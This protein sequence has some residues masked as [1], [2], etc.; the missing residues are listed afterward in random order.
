MK[1]FLQ[2]MKRDALAPPRRAWAMRHW[3]LSLLLLVMLQFVGSTAKAQ[4]PW[5]YDVHGQNFPGTL[6][7]Y[8]NFNFFCWDG[9][10]GAYDDEVWLQVNGKDVINLKTVWSLISGSRNNEDNLKKKNYNW[11]VGTPK[12][13]SKNGYRGTVALSN[14]RNT[15]GKWMG[16]TVDLILERWIYN[17]S[18]EITIRGKWRYKDNSTSNDLKVKV[19]TFNFPSMSWP[20]IDFKRTADGV[21]QAYST[22]LLQEKYNNCGGK[23][24]SGT[25]RYAYRFSKKY[26]GNVNWPSEP[27]KIE[28]YWDNLNSTPKKVK[29]DFV[30]CTESATSAY[31]T[32]KLDNFEA[33]CLHPF[34]TR[35][36]PNYRSYPLNGSQCIENN[37]YFNRS[38]ER[39]HW[40]NGY[41]RPKSIS[42]STNSWTKNVILSWTPE[43]AD[44]SHVTK[45]GKWVVFRRKSGS[46]TYE[47]LK[48]LAYSDKQVS[49]TDEDTKDY[50]TTYYYYVAFQPNEWNTSIMKPEDATNLY[51]STYTS[52]ST[53]N[54]LKS[55]LAS[56]NLDNKIT[57][58]CSFYSFENA[59]SSNPYKLLVYRRA[60]G[61]TDWGEVFHETTISDKNVTS[62]SFDDTKIAN[63]CVKYQYM[64][65][66]AAQ[67]TTFTSNICDGGI[68]GNSEVTSVNASRGAYSGTV[69]VNWDVKQVGTDLTYFNVRR[70]LLGS[71]AEYQNIYTTSGVA[72]TYTYEDNSAQPGSYYQ[73]EVECYRKCKETGTISP[74][75]S[76]ETDGFALATG[77]VSGRISYDTGTAVEGVKVIAEANNA[78]GE[79]LTAFHAL[80]T[81]KDVTCQVGIA[82]P[83]E[84]MASLFGNPWTAQTYIKID[85]FPEN[86]MHVFATNFFY[87]AVGSTGD[88]SIGLSYLKNNNLEI[89]RRYLD[90]KITIAKGKFYNASVSFDGNATYT[91][92]VIG[93]NGKFQSAKVQISDP[94]AYK[95]VD[96]IL[97]ANRDYLPESGLWY[98]DSRVDNQTYSGVIDECRFWTKEL[99]DDQIKKNYNHTL[100][101]SEDGLYLYYK[102][103]EGITN[104]TIAY[105]YSKTGGVSNGNHGKIVDMEITDDVPSENQ[106]SLSAI[107]DVNGN[108]TISG[109][110]FSGDGTSYTIRPSMGGHEFSAAKANRFVSAQ[111][112]VHNGVDFQDVSSFPVSGVVYYQGTTIPVEG[113]QFAVDGVSC[114][115]DGEFIQTNEKG[116]YTISVP[117]GYHYISAS[118]L[119]HEFCNAD[120]K[121]YKGMG[122]YP[123]QNE[124]ANKMET[125]EFTKLMPNIIFYDTT[126]VPIVGRVT[127]GAVEN[128]K[129]LGLGQSVNN[130]GQA[131]LTLKASD[132]Y[133]MNVSVE[134]NG[135]AYEYVT[136]K[137]DRVFAVPADAVCNSTT[138]VGSGSADNARI[139][140][141]KT[142]PKTGEFAAM[143]PPLQYTVTGIK[144]D[145]NSDISWN[146]AE[147]INATDP[148]ATSA[149][150]IEVEDGYKKFEYVASL[151]KSYRS[152]AILDVVQKNVE[153]EGAFGEP[154][155]ELVAEDGTKKSIELYNKEKTFTL[156]K[157]ANAD[158][159]TFGYPIFVQGGNY[160]FDLS[161]YE[162]YFNHDADA[163][164]KESK[165]PL[166][167][168]TVNITNQMGFGT[169]VYVTGDKDGEVYESSQTEIE[170]DSLGHGTYSWQAGSPNI[171]TPYTRTLTMS[172]PI[173]GV[174]KNWSGNGFQGIVL[175]QLTSGSNFVT[176]G[177]DEV[178]MILRDPAGSGSNAYVEEGQSF[179]TTK[180]RG[181]TIKY[182]NETSVKASMGCETTITT[183]TAGMGALVTK[184]TKIEVK[185]E[186][187]VGV[188]IDEEVRMGN[189]TVQT[190][191]TTKRISTSDQPEYVGDQGDVFIGS[192][193]N[194]NFGNAR[195]VGIYA[196]DA[197][198]VPALEKRDVMSVGTRYGTEFS[199][200]QNY[201]ENVLLPNF[202]KLRN[203]CLVHVN[204]YDGYVNNTD[205]PVYITKLSN[206][207]S[208]LGSNNSDKKVWGAKASKSGELSGESY[209]MVLP[210]SAYN[211]SQLK[212]DY[213]AS[214]TIAWYNAQISAWTQVLANNEK[215]KVTAIENAEYKRTNYSFDAGS[216]VSSSTQSVNSKDFTVESETSLL[217]V[218]SGK[219]GFAFDGNGVEVFTKEEKGG[220][221][222]TS[223]GS[224]E[225]SSRE[226]GFSLVET[227][228]AD[229]LSIDVIDAPDGF[230]PIFYTRAGQTSCPYEDEVKTKYY[231]PGTTIQTKTAQVEQP[232]LS[233]KETSVTGVPSGKP[234][235][236]TIYLQNTSEADIDSYFNLNVVDSSNPNG[237]A[238]KMDGKDVT[239]GRTILV[240]AGET[241]TKTL[242]ISQTNP[243]IYD[244]KDLQLRMSSTC[245]SNIE[246]ILKLSA[247]FQ[248]TSSDVSLKAAE[249]AV[250]LETGTSMH[251]TISNYDKNA[252]GMKSVRLQVQQQGNPQWL[253][254]KEWVVSEKE[255]AADKNKGLLPDEG[256][257]NYVF[258]MANNDTYPD[259]QWNIRTITVSNFGGEEVTK[260]SEVISFYKDMARPQVIS[261]PN[262]SNGVLTADSEISLTFNEDIRSGAM[263][264]ADNFSIQGEL[265]DAQVAHDVAL[266]LTGGEG[267]KTNANFNLSNKSFAVNMW[268][269]YSAKGEVFSHGTKA[270]RMTVSVADDDKMVVDVN[271]QKF[272][273]DNA[274]KKNT[275]QFVSFSYDAEKQTF[276]ANYAY[277][278]FDVVLFNNLKVGE[279]KG[280]GP[281]TLGEKMQGQIHDVSL[282]NQARPWS[283]AQNEMYERKTRYSDGLMGYWRLDEGHGGLATD[284]ARSRNLVLPSAT[285]WYLASKNYALALDG[286]TVVAVDASKIAT[287]H[288]ESYLAEF[289]FRAEEKQNG[290]ANVFGFNNKDKFDIFVD[291]AGLLKMNVN[292]ADYAIGSD[293][294]TDNQWHHV[295][296]N[297]LKSTSGSATV[298]LD[299]VAK[300]Q[301]M[302]SV[303]PAIQTS[304]LLLGGKYDGAQATDMLKGAID[305]IRIWKGRRM[306]DVIKNNMYAR[307]NKASDG[308]IAYYP[309]EEGGLDEGNAPTILATLSDQSATRSGEVKPVNVPVTLAP[310]SDNVPA[311]KSVPDKQNVSFEYVASERKILVNLT[312][313]PQRIEGCTLTVTV[314]NVRDSHNN[315]S[316][317]VTWDVYVRQNQLVWKQD[318]VET[319]KHGTE[320]VSIEAEIN[321]NSGTTESWTISGLPSWLTLENETG[322]LPALSSK[323]LTFAVD[324]ALAIGSQEATIYLTGNLG[325]PEPMVIKVNSTSVAPDWSVNSADYEFTMN[326]NGQLEINGEMSQDVN[327]I[328]AA[329]RGDRCVGVAKPTYFS[330][331]DAYYVLM[332]V[333]GNA[334]DNGKDLTYKV[335]EAKTGRVL[336]M[337]EVSMDKANMFV[338][339][340]IVGTISSP[341]VWNAQEK[342]E[343]ILNLKKGWQWSS[344]YVNSDN[345][346]ADELL[347]GIKNQVNYMISENGQ[348]T[349]T[350]N[351]INEVVA[352]EM[353]K[354][355]GNAPVS[356]SVVGDAIDVA[357]DPV[358]IKP[359]WNWIGYKA[360]GYVSIGNAFADLEPQEGD[361]VKSQTAFA[362][363]NSSEWVG[364]LE[365]LKSGEGYL[366]YST[367]NQQQTFHYPSATSS[368]AAK[369]FSMAKSMSLGGNDAANEKAEI[370]QKHQGN[371]NVIAR[372]VDKHGAVRSDAVVRVMDGEGELRA[373]SDEAHADLYF[374]TI[375]GENSGA[376]LRFIV[377]VDGMEQVIPGTMFYRDDAIVGSLDQPLV[378]DLASTTGI[379]SVKT[380]EDSSEATYDLNGRRVAKHAIETVVIR[381]NKKFVHLNK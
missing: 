289:W 239:A 196:A 69:R 116:E 42:T 178:I 189:T 260:S 373:L 202:K 287:T 44:P 75:A 150:S 149:D 225:E 354:I 33:H 72:E 11:V 367:R 233:A 297:V 265:N 49:Y 91:V 130:I 320:K 153:A 117:I 352:G 166:A 313:Q 273:S 162:K 303:L 110:P 266:N 7:V 344:F 222:T 58:T 81:T 115:K 359:N 92:R 268:M 181:G 36:A 66:V 247:Y 362:S 131:T 111:S 195:Q 363:W 133:S 25:L 232:H 122:Y 238:V 24:K 19:G 34:I 118:K 101:G 41:P 169:S 332:N 306:G 292:G 96:A 168:N 38:Y 86:G 106:L 249:S 109:V 338:T 299:G 87:F 28:T 39:D 185:N 271:G 46:S 263:S 54:P 56:N 224:T 244:Y 177:P 321:N 68:D 70:R 154:T 206:T 250:N 79:K 220:G 14:I 317:N 13:F 378:I 27:I 194:Y 355:Q 31:V 215:A 175:G 331:Y 377:S 47:K 143:V 198:S 140:T 230:G 134:K 126:L 170:L 145:S 93:E 282:W 211:G 17:N 138:T 234:A 339:D 121:S 45:E 176:S 105:D 253:T 157:T 361:V 132:T 302:A 356:L 307:V 301:M 147:I 379:G 380:D 208:R 35:F 26:E 264:K 305:E 293:K 357:N 82:K 284:Y 32:M 275:W 129:P 298:Y 314:K 139:I 251:L 137:T 272:T 335:F 161:L 61:T 261:N 350:S 351:S 12:S 159:Y 8:F 21:V 237:A 326:V 231:R 371:M 279:Y 60:K 183:G 227:G 353:Y 184:D 316:E 213:V 276:N 172:Y 294:V 125:F 155:Y 256:T 85:Q 65:K 323:K 53:S 119:G 127:G 83:K 310:T 135:Q 51:K 84:T 128:E 258:S 160:E 200:T 210:K 104:Q 217:I 219:L 349:P 98:G 182:A 286:K 141:I 252:R 345:G 324:P 10:N 95:M 4:T 89:D 274:F 43:I 78:D 158:A 304:K 375:A 228:D 97:S 365:A 59:T 99:T 52:I 364:S 242:Q 283:E 337:V 180:M 76:Q 103:D 308:L 80:G 246:E 343:Q 319:V 18:N 243:D 368:A 241:V 114:T 370:A 67:E 207:D 270:G 236:F 336:P 107:T 312:E 187:E 167:N 328:V 209:K 22:N 327:D 191:T 300:K 16:T 290:K 325:V 88:L 360:P 235:T 136:A 50:N 62:H 248:Q 223:D 171:L 144:I 376:N 216:S 186:L 20:D 142:D 346:S 192:S 73:Y 163:P 214:D 102:F 340:N 341:N 2:Q 229:A 197:N 146:T 29:T 6:H 15:G 74:G 278:A 366:Y 295:A 164:V 124:D 342:V 120:G 48:E 281:V 311:L 113:V 5:V 9:D 3:A 374:I 173:D 254:V 221:A 64:M 199:Y 291:E 174:E 203:S 372:V 100:S 151:K 245:D 156:P 148:Q 71:D 267:A 381:G 315:Y 179:S 23:D 269:R 358:V 201:V 259:G 218:G 240:P 204:S 334:E 30:D 347:A 165:V 188:K 330:R 322:Y 40:V 348:W 333:Y 1:H 226:V 212:D 329:F 318:E 205:K 77:V 55:I 57:V 112:L 90:K 108:Y 296:V 94:S 309:F 123:T 277:D 255:A 262:P 63:A 280:N 152:P 257:F 190:I 369:E 37:V 288:E 193:V 285:A